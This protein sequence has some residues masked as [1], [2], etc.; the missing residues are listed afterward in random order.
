MLVLSFGNNVIQ[1]SFVFFLKNVFFFR[2][3]LVAQSVKNLPVVQADQDSIPGL[4]E[5]MATHSGILAWRIPTERRAWWAIVHGV[6]K[7]MDTTERLSTHT[8]HVLL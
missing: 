5:G 2:A 7:E 8:A 4:G 3:S 1:Y 6:K